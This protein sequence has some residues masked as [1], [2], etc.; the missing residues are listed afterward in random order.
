MGQL[1]DTRLVWDDVEEIGSF[2]WE[3]ICPNETKLVWDGHLN[4]N[5]SQFLHNFKY[6]GMTSTIVEII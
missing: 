4:D 1:D 6:C 2:K 5:I 3:V